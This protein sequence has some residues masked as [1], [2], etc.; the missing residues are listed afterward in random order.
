[1]KG[2]QS[3]G[4]GLGLAFVAAVAQ[5]HGGQVKVDDR[6]AGGAIILLSLPMSEVLTTKT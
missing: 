3:S 5:A 4:H 1:V 2:E 6:P